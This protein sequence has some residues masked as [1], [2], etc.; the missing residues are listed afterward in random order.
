MK[1]KWKIKPR[2]KKTKYYICERCDVKV[3]ATSLKK[4]NEYEPSCLKNKN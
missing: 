4:A 2:G 3:T 1:H